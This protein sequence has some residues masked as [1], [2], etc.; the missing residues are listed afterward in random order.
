MIINAGVDGF[1]RLITFIRCANNNLA[2]TILE[3]FLQG[4][5]IY[6]LPKAVWSDH[7]GENVDVWRHVLS[8]HQVPSYVVTGNLCIM[9]VM[10]E[11]D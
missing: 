9:N 3:A 1:S 8:I 10:K 6:G 7:D 5:S 11:Y 4:V 2:S